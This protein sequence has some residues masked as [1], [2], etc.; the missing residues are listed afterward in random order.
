MRKRQAQRIWRRKEA[1]PHRGGERGAE[2]IAGMAAYAI[3]CRGV[4]EME[5]S[6]IRIAEKVSKRAKSGETHT[7]SRPWLSS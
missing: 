6:E 3:F 4:G 5:E 7:K 2:T 1:P